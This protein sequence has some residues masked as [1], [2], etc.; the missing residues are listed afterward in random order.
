MADGLNRQAD[1]IAQP[2][3]CPPSTVGTRSPDTRG[4]SSHHQRP[5]PARRLCARDHIATATQSVRARSTPRV[6]AT[7]TA[8]HALNSRTIE[9]KIQIIGV[10]PLIASGPR[11]AVPSSRGESHPPALTEPCVTVSRY[12]A[13]VAL[14]VRSARRWSAELG[15]SARTCGGIAGR[16]PA[17]SPAP[18]AWPRAARTSCGSSAPGRH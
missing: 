1:G 15:A 2:G 3:C 12:T 10:E 11:R 5:E 16:S 17:A 6:Q 18:S 9:T 14:F 8:R 7:T 4:A 13:L